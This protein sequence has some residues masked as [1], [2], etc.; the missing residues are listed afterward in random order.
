MKVWHIDPAVQKYKW[1]LA[2]PG[3]GVLYAIHHKNT[4]LNSKA[5][6][7]RAACKTRPAS[8]RI[9]GSRGHIK[10]SGKSKSLIHDAIAKYGWENFD[11]HII[12]L[13]PE[14]MLDDAEY[15]AVCQHKTKHPNGYNIKDGGGTPE[16]QPETIARIKE[17]RANWSEERKAEYAS[18]MSKAFTDERKVEQSIR[19]TE[20]WQ[21]SEFRDRMEGKS[22]T[23]WSERTEDELKQHGQ[24]THEKRLSKKRKLAIETAVPL[25]APS[26]RK[27][28]AFYQYPDGSIRTYYAGK[29]SGSWHVV[30]PAPSD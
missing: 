22:K 24:K 15:E 26:M 10:G 4:S 25:P 6:I 17:V 7:G 3:Y 9:F 21:T 23:W 2:P 11:W 30:V 27:H 16:I 18:N 8:Y 13:L 20:L 12:E 19:Q 5:Y 29:I 1:E 28:K 14:D